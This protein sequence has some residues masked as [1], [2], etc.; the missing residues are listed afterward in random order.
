MKGKKGRGVEHAVPRK[1]GTIG[2]N[3]YKYRLEKNITMKALAEKSGVTVGILVNF[4]NNG[5]LQVGISN[6][7]RIAWALGVRVED[8][9]RDVKPLPSSKSAKPV[10]DIPPVESGTE[11]V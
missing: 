5:R 7:I 2:K 11:D 8:L 6:L 3:M 4:E 10:N 1:P 9:L